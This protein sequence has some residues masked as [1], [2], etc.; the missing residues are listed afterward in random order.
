M[1]EIQKLLPSPW[2]FSENT[3]HC[4]GHGFALNLLNAPHHHALKWNRKKTM[5]SLVENYFVSVQQLHCNNDNYPQ[6]K[7]WIKRKD[8]N[9]SNRR[10][11]ILS[12]WSLTMWTPEMRERERSERRKKRTKSLLA[13]SLLYLNGCSTCL[14]WFL[15]LFGFFD[16][17]TIWDT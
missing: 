8:F 3:Q 5:W 12:W 2:I 9:A 6:Q 13:M 17:I 11:S 7:R 4:A 10:I 1:Y 15:W 16:D 14:K